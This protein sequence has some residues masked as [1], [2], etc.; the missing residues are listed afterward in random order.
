MACTD[1]KNAYMNIKELP[2]ITDIISGDFLIVETPTAT[3]I[4]DYDN[5]VITLD[6]TT[7]G[8]TI[9][10]N[11]TNIAAVSSD[12]IDLENTLTANVASLSSQDLNT[13]SRVSNLSSQVSILSSQV[14]E[15]NLQVLAL[16]S[17]TN[18]QILALSSQTTSLSTSTARNNTFVTFSLPN[19]NSTNSPVILQQSNVSSVTLNTTASA[20]VVAFKTN[21][22]NDTYCITTGVTN[23]TPVMVVN[24]SAGTNQAQFSLRA[25]PALTAYST[26]TKVSIQI[27][28][29]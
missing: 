12:V 27:I 11:T 3:S 26:A 29:V 18:L 28:S 4:L 21:F 2:E 16:S 19:Y 14:T 7:F 22:E 1:G 8:D 9:I 6:N 24:T 5:F 10:N 23:G 25:A 15:T 13:N 17:Q 20:V